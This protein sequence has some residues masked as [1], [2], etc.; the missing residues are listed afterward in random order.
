[1]K[2]VTLKKWIGI[3]LVSILLLGASGKLTDLS[4]KAT[5][6]KIHKPGREAWNTDKDFLLKEGQRTGRYKNSFAFHTVGKV[7]P[8]I[9]ID[10]TK[11]CQVKKFV[12]ENRRDLIKRAK[13]LTIWLSENKEDWDQVWQAKKAK[14]EWIIELDKAQKARYVK[15][16]LTEKTPLHLNKVRIYGK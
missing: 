3:F 9:I 5:L 13:T 14:K 15:I 1:M 8:Y 4:E 7:L 10:L 12:I 16:G 2:L 6:I 11:D